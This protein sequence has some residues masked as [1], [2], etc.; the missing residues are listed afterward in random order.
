M[1]PGP[2]G[3]WLL[4]N[5]EDLKKD[6]L[7]YLLLWHKQHGDFVK[8]R[9]GHLNMV[10]VC[11]PDLIHEVLVTKASSF[12]KDVAIKN[13]PEFFGEGLLRSEGE[14]WKRQRKL[15]AP[16]FSPKRLEEYAS[17]MIE[18]VSEMLKGWQD[19]EL[20]DIQIEM[21]RLTLAIA[22][23][24]LFDADVKEHGVA[25]EEALADAQKYLGERLE[26]LI[27]LLLPQWVPFPTNVH[28]HDAIEKCNKV[29]YKLIQERRG[30]T[31]GRHDLLSS[32]I[33]ARDEDGSQMSDKQIRDE[34]F[35]LFFAGH[36]TTALTLT[37]TL[38]LISKNPEVEA[39]LLDELQSVLQDRPIE[40]NDFHRLNYTRKVIFE[41]MRLRPPV[42]AIAREAVEDCFIGKYD[43]PKGVSIMISQWVNNQDERWFSNAQKFDPDRW[44]AEFHENLPKFAYFP[45]GGGPRTC[46]GNNF[47][48]LEA[49]LLLAAIMREYHLDTEPEQ[50][51]VLQPAATLRPKNGIKMSLHK[52]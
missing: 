47:A 42:W 45:F 40:A 50:N 18:E 16:S 37:W 11:N 41:S 5:A 2:R 14:F 43:V 35:T 38:H 49:V 34:V 9:I 6:P 36:E 48:L 31:E 1:P 10:L 44:T 25:F 26:D 51:I 19:G 32:L 13:N 12:S 29:V 46:I 24:T 20:V 33:D 52:R 23:K 4:G 27:I 7:K 17:T 30:K 3:D 21:M 39:K 22:S 8:L 15:A 28:L